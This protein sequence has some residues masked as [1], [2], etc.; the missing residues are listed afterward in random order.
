VLSISFITMLNTGLAQLLYL[1]SVFFVGLIIP[2][3]SVVA[4][5]K[6]ATTLPQALNFIPLAFIT[7]AYPYFARNRNNPSWIR[8]RYKQSLMWMGLFGLIIAL[9]GIV[10][11]PVIIRL[12]FGA[13]YMD[14]VLPF[15]IL[16]LS[17]ALGSTFRVLSGNILVTQREL[18]FN[19]IIS[20]VSGVL[21]IVLNMVFI[22]LWHSTGAAIAQL[23]VVIVTGLCSTIYMFHILKRNQQKLENGTCQNNM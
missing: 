14:S 10:A 11:A 16:M 1:L 20:V 18:K 4:S 6:V 12:L 2:D 15:R 3:D 23:I 17:F 9:A 5:Y 7:Y 13:Q 19:L 21:S 22:G 8:R